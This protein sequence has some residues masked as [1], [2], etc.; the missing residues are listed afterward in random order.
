MNKSVDEII[1]EW[2]A[3]VRDPETFHDEFI[4][5]KLDDVAAVCN[6]FDDLKTFENSI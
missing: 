2:S 5:V 3:E 4:T 6:Y 1:K